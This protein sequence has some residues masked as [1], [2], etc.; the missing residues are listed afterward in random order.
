MLWRVTKSQN[1]A[2]FGWSVPIFSCSFFF[3][4]FFSPFLFSLSSIRYLLSIS[5]KRFGLNHSSENL[6]IRHWSFKGVLAYFTTNFAQIIER[7]FFRLPE[8]C[9]NLVHIRN[10]HTRFKIYPSYVSCWSK[11]PGHVQIDD[12]TSGSMPNAKKGLFLLQD[13]R[14]HYGAVG[15]ASSLYD[16]MCLPLLTTVFSSNKQLLV[17]ITSSNN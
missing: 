7:F 9:Q 8:L 2:F 3:L 10:G 1:L 12:V 11:Q 14:Q 4:S 15:L 16:F 17:V 5:W 13:T 6:E